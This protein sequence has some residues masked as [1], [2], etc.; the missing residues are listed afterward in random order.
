MRI[1]KTMR[2]VVVLFAIIA[3]LVFSSIHIHKSDE[4]NKDQYSW[5]IEGIAERISEKKDEL[6]VL[7]TEFWS[8]LSEQRELYMKG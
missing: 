4:L 6:R 8:A 5:R 3:I 2:F 7:Y 1:G